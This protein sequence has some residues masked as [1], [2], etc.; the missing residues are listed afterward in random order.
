MFEPLKSTDSKNGLHISGFMKATTKEDDGQRV[1][2]NLRFRVI[3][4]FGLTPST[5]KQIGHLNICKMYKSM[6]R[7]TGAV[8][9]E[10]G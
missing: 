8:S 9:F 10:V 2:E 7:R 3:K 6:H 5:T 1:G 4:M